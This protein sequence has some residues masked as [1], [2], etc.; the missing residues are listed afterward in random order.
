MADAPACNDSKLAVID[1]RDFALRVLHHG[2]V[3][4]SLVG[5]K[6]GGTPGGVDPVGADKQHID[7]ELIKRVHGGRPDERK[8]IAAQVASCYEHADILALRQLHGDVHCVGDDC[9]VVIVRNST[10]DFGGGGAGR[11]GNRLAMLDQG[12]GG[13]PDSALFCGK[14]GDLCLKRTIVA[15][16]LVKQRLDRFGSAV[17]T[18]EQSAFFETPEIPPDSHDR[19]VEAGTELFDRDRARLLQ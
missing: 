19:D 8:P 14:A 13:S 5:V 9:D 3:Q 15:E 10:N 12:G 7:Y 18:A 2:A 4:R 6:G 17:G 1:N 16:W 11:E